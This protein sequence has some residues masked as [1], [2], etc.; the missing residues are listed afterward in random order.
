MRFPRILCMTVVLCGVSITAVFAA[1]MRRWTDSSG[2]NSIQ[3]AFVSLAN[4]KVTLEGENGKKFEIELD[5]LSKA[6]QTYVKD[7]ESNPFKEAASSPFKPAGSGMSSQKPQRAPVNSSD[8]SGKLLVVR[9]NRKRSNQIRTDSQEEWAYQPPGEI[10]LEFKPRHI[11]LPKAA[12]VFEKLTGIAPNLA[13]GKVA[14][15]FT[16]GR[17]GKKPT[18]TISIG[19]L[20]TGRV[21]ISEEISGEYTPLALHDDG[22]HVVVRSNGFASQ[23]KTDLFIWH[24][25][26]GDPVIEKQFQPYDDSLAPHNE[27]T[28]AEFAANG[29]LITCSQNGVIVGW[30]F[31]TC[32]PV[33]HVQ[34]GNNCIPALSPDRTVLAFYAQKQIVLLDVAHQKVIGVTSVPREPS[35]PA[36]AFSPSGARIA[37]AAHTSILVWN[38]I[39][40]EL[41]RDVPLKSIH[42]GGHIGFPAESFVL[43]GNQYLVDVDNEIP[44]WTYRSTV[45][46]SVTRGLALL[47]SSNLLQGGSIYAVTL[48]HPEAVQLLETIISKPE[49]VAYRAG[50]P[51]RLDVSKIPADHQNQVRDALT[52]ALGTVRSTV[53]E[54]APVTVM[55]SITGPASRKIRFMHAGEFDI[56]EYLSKIDIMY[57]NE[58][59]WGT[60]STNVPFFVTLKKGENIATKLQEL[61]AKPSYGVFNSVRF[62]KVVVKPGQGIKADQ[63]TLGASDIDRK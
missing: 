1:E 41:E 4:G 20:T 53:N 51:V 28:W 37:C 34:A 32:Q 36:L 58:R 39:T 63:P 2:K 11:T 38:G 16:S 10:P 3:A 6:D 22:E 40:G 44:L 42:I 48:P 12:D 55:A 30:N 26:G 62:P 21:K 5:Q 54:S 60:T 56:Q 15:G 46:S 43:L 23:N 17:P 9:V 35:F 13:A 29:E 25:S 57:Q 27:I 24:I 52:K 49:L 18:T 33:F 14:F 8:S 7:Q 31:E 59:A 19:D 61:G 47:A 50:D 45:Q